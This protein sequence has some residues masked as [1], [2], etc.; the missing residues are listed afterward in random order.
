MKK[1]KYWASTRTHCDICFTDITPGNVAYFVDGKMKEGQGAWALMCP[2]CFKLHGVGLGLGLGQKY[3]G[4]SKIPYLLE[5]N[6]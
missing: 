5:K 3:D 2:N 6:D 1:R 4:M